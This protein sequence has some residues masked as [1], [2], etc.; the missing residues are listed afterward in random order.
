M[1]P[2][3]KVDLRGRSRGQ[4]VL[5][6]LKEVGHAGIWAHTGGVSKSQ[7]CVPDTQ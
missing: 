3:G 7:L 6:L 4:E 1:A 5:N 2:M